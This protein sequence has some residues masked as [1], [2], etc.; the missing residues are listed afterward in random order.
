MNTPTMPLTDVKVKNLKSRDK[1]YKVSDFDG[2]F[3]LVNPS[4]SKLWRFKYRIYGKEKLLS[5][6]AY[7]EISLAQAREV[8][9]EARKHVATGNDP[10][11][12]KKER[13]IREMEIHGQTF[14]K[15]ADAYLTKLEREGRRPATLKKNQWLLAKANSAFGQEPL[16]KISSAT[17][18]AALKKVESEGHLESATRLRTVIGS[19]FRF[20]IANALTEN[21]PT[22]A[23][24][25][26][27]A[28]PVV[29]N[30]PALLTWTEVRDFV[31]AS[32][33][34]SGQFTTRIGL[35]LTV[36]LAVRPGEL[37][38]AEWMDFD[39]DQAVLTIP[40]SRMKNKKIHYVPLSPKTL[41]LLAQL[42]PLTGSGK[43]VLPSLRTNRRPIS[44]G[45][46][47]AAMRRMGYSGDEVTAHGFRATFSTLANE[48]GLWNP[49]AIDKALSHKITSSS[50]EAATY[51]RSEYWD[52]RVELV[53][54]WTEA[55]YEIASD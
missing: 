17:V 54:W 8:R 2:L 12:I 41:D 36:M 46:L 55:V 44:D 20:G 3:V 16:S 22:Y 32:R 43:Y 33:E 28:R 53:N 5:I 9:D 39:V 15:V 6:G 52:L 42:H 23:L 45:T 24:R 4:G 50:R 27:L 34:Y 14:A 18:L 40:A 51:N 7:P 1:P 11:Q 26:A 35:E 47:N 49:D 10:S 13:R 25:G 21:D 30:R 38:L 31:R 37:R 19:V 48:S 29:T